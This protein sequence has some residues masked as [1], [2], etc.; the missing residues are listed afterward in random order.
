MST[1]H[2]F[3]QKKVQGLDG[4]PSPLLLLHEAI[5]GDL[6]LRSV[7]VETDR[8][9]D[10]AR[11]DSIVGHYADRG[12]T[13]LHITPRP[14]GFIAVLAPTRDITPEHARALRDVVH[15]D[16]AA[17]LK[18]VLK[19][20]GFLTGGEYTFFS[21]TETL[22][23]DGWELSLPYG[24]LRVA[25]EPSA[26][27]ANDGHASIKRSSA[28]QLIA[29]CISRRRLT[30]KSALAQAHR[31]LKGATHLQA[32]FVGAHGSSKGLHVLRDDQDFEAQFGTDVHAVSDAENLKDEMWFSPGHFTGKLNIWRPRGR[33]SVVLTASEDLRRRLTTD[34]LGWDQAA[35]LQTASFQRLLSEARH[36]ITSGEHFTQE[37]A[38]FPSWTQEVYQERQLYNSDEERGIATSFGWTGSIYPKLFGG[39]SAFNA[40]PGSRVPIQGIM[41]VLGGNGDHY[42]LPRPQAGY[43]G[44]ATD[45]GG[46]PHAA[47]I[48]PTDYPKVSHILDTAD[49]DGDLVAVI[50]ARDPEC[51]LSQDPEVLWAMVLRTPASPG[52]VAWL[53]LTHADWQRL[54]DAGA[55]PVTVNG[56]V[57]Y[58]EFMLPDESGRLPV[59]T[60]RPIG[61]MRT[62]QAWDTTPAQQVREAIHI[63]NEA[64]L[65]G[66]FYRLMTAAHNGDI[67]HLQT[68]TWLEKLY[69]EH[70]MEP[71]TTGGAS[72][73]F[74]DFVDSVG[75]WLTPP[76][77]AMA[78]ILCTAVTEH[79]L[80][81]DR[82]IKSSLWQPMFQ[83]LSR[84]TDWDNQ[85]IAQIL[86]SA[87]TPN[88]MGDHLRTT[89]S[90]LTSSAWFDREM[91]KL[92]LM[93]NGPATLLMTHPI[94]FPGELVATVSTTQKQIGRFWAAKFAADREIDSQTRSSEP[95][96]LDEEETLQ[97]TPYDWSL[98]TQEQAAQQKAAA[99]QRTANAVAQ[100]IATSIR[101]SGYPP[102]DYVSA[103][104]RLSALSTNRFGEPNNGYRQPPQPTNTTT[105]FRALSLLQRDDPEIAS[106]AI[107]TFQTE[108][109][110]N[111]PT[112]LVRLS[113]PGAILPGDRAEIRLNSATGEYLLCRDGTQPLCRVTAGGA[114]LLNLPLTYVGNPQPLD[115]T[116]D[117]NEK[118]DLH[119]FIVHDVHPQTVSLPAHDPGEFA[120]DEEV[121]I[122]RESTPT[123]PQYHL[124]TSHK[125]LAELLKGNR[126]AKVNR[127]AL[128][129]VHEH[130][131]NRPM[132]FAGLAANGNILL[133][134]EHHRT[135]KSEKLIKDILAMLLP[136]SA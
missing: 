21:T 88:C 79:G 42:G 20:D 50:P 95:P 131:I 76:I 85:R 15:Y 84:T 13:I 123:G 25:Y 64:A 134:D 47:L 68:P 11:A 32:F 44:F 3:R 118:Q 30:G 31:V 71:S 34:V 18:K 62:A 100:L 40:S 5:L 59:H 54:N 19:R 45:D 73:C 16:R 61:D 96:L 77:D 106:Q 130:L 91:L 10:P 99:Y 67:L 57:P 22:H 24:L 125:H 55:M 63:R 58:R 120:P 129:G 66:V 94:R 93:A 69:A 75:K 9:L 128:K 124:A 41:A 28:E 27:N 38:V 103:W 104:I 136:A 87:F 83:A 2:G 46:R 135:S 82:C 39:V 127:T 33:W 51:H 14:D 92:Q 53:R 122:T 80:K 111:G 60:I 52:G 98:L 105:L 117:T 121:S 1:T 119:L 72:T 116:G 37:E 56:P 110:G 78:E 35:S 90:I 48:N 43:V 81:L 112:A 65:I 4:N 36:R 12:W 89:Q 74:S 133:R 17:P 49:H 108:W 29:T 102:L 114:L 97:H 132:R 115:P 109:P 113:D 86:N 7:S 70:G 101:E 6:E 107:K 8:G 126:Q 23:Q 26:L